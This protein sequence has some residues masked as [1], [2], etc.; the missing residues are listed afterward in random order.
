MTKQTYLCMLV[1][2]IL[3]GLLASCIQATSL[4]TLT[5][6]ILPTSTFELITPSETSPLPNKNDTVSPTA[7]P[8]LQFVTVTP[9][10]TT[11][12][13]LLQ[14]TYVSD[15]PCET[16]LYGIASTIYA[17]DVGCLDAKTLC[18]S[19]PRQLFEWDRWIS[20]ADW[21]PDG[22]RLVFESEGNLFI[23]NWNGTDVL[24]LPSD[25]GSEHSPR[26]SPEGDQIAYIFL[27][28]RPESEA[29]GPALIQVYDIA[30]GQ[31][32]SIMDGFYD[33]HGVDWLPTGEISI[34]AKVSETDWT[35]VINIVSVDGTV[36]RQLPE[37]A[38]DYTQIG[39]LAFSPEQQELAFVGIINPT[40][41]KTTTNIYLTD[42]NGNS[43]INITTGM[44]YIISLVWSPLG[45]WLAF[46]SN[47]E[48]DW[49]IYLIKP[50]GTQ[51]ELVTQSTSD[52]SYP[53]WRMIP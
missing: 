14:L 42:M 49:S 18:F 4:P 11:E 9:T 53:A 17:I 30:S 48:G 2:I 45:N 36:I 24:Q 43:A 6:E 32:T 47:R 1:Q 34:I 19:E 41:G 23:G 51:L 7:S 37:N 22:N 3:I 15:R 10:P 44:G 5:A 50:D 52:E 38:K 28:Q 20:A 26:W 40:T 25:P 46:A 16:C 31:I 27:P 29:L 33:P 12:N 21:S 13:P 35:E 8:T 39:G